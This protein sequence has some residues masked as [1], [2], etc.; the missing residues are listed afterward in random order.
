[1]VYSQVIQGNNS[2]ILWLTIF[3]Y[4]IHHVYADIAQCIVI[5]RQNY[6]S[7][8]LIRIKFAKH[9]SAFKIKIICLIL[10]VQWRISEQIKF[11]LPQIFQKVHIVLPIK[12]FIFEIAYIFSQ[13]FTEMREKWNNQRFEWVLFICSYSISCNYI[14]CGLRGF[15]SHMIIH[16]WKV[17][18]SRSISPMRF[19]D[20]LISLEFDLGD[21]SRARALKHALS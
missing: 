2:E 8:Y 5:L 3:L 1:M 15:L 4:I 7:H 19:D 20:L 11:S 14:S 6:H 18:L 16:V 17:S 10:P 12:Q 9:F 21:F 13:N